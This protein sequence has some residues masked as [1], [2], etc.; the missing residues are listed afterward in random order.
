MPLPQ[1]ACEQMELLRINVGLG[2]YAAQVNKSIL[3]GAHFTVGY[4]TITLKPIEDESNVDKRRHEIV[5]QP[6]DKYMRRQLKLHA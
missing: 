6:S 5:L 4:T 3:R 1:I 2:P